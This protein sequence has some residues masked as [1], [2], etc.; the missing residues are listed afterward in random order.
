MRDLRGRGD[1]AVGESEP[2]G[3]GNRL[4]KVVFCLAPAARG[5]LDAGEQL[6]RER[7]AGTLLSAL[8]GVGHG[9]DRVG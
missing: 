9:G 6:A 1:L 4:V 8:F 2:G 7:G 3:A 5:T